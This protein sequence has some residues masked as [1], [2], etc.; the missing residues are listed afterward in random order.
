[1]RI[2]SALH[3]SLSAILSLCV[4]GCA[5]AYKNSVNFNPAEPIRIAV[6]PFAQVDESGA[7]TQ[8]D[9]SYLIDNVSLV[10]SKLKQTPA[11]F[12]QSLVQSELSKASL[13][14]VTPAVVE[15]AFAHNGF[16]V[17][18]SNPVRLDLAKVFAANP[19][20]ICAKL[21]SCDAVLYGKVTEWDRSYYA[22]QSVATVAINV[23]LVSARTGKVLF[24]SSASDSDSRGITKGPTGFSNLVIEPLKGLDNEIITDLAREVV[25]KA[26]EPL[27]RKARPDFLKTAPPYIL[28]SAHDASSGA[29][30]GEKLTVLVLG[31]PEMTGSFSIGSSVRDMPLV[32]RSPGHYIG[33]YIAVGGNSFTEQ[34]VTVSLQD[35]GGRKTEQSLSKIPVSFR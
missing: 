14:V 22:V 35:Q 18:E 33:E 20:E 7:L 23:K 3:F 11:Q 12:V 17:K 8:T 30:R 34:V 28:A 32:E 24:E 9:E 13:D 19:A 29:I 6:L 5:G 26:I 27:D 25:A 31:T 2:H 10:S 4:T 21:L 16:G 15:A 1:M